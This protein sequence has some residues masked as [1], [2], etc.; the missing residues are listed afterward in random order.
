MTTVAGFISE[1]AQISLDRCVFA[2]KRI[3]KLQAELD[4]AT[5]VIRSIGSRKCTLEECAEAN[6]LAKVRR[7]KIASIKR[8][9][10]EIAALEQDKK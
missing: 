10:K 4:A 6:R 3:A 8:W 5:A 7:S 2:R 1:Q 9:Y